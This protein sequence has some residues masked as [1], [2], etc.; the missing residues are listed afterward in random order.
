MVYRRDVTFIHG[1]RKESATRIRR[2][3]DQ[4]LILFGFYALTIIIIIIVSDIYIYKYIVLFF[5]ILHFY[6]LL[7]YN[8]TSYMTT[9]LDLPLLVP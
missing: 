6:Q 7:F 3:F 1:Q 9:L 5:S 8:D 4:N 2:Y